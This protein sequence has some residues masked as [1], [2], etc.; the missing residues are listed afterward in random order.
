[1]DTPRIAAIRDVRELSPWRAAIDALNLASRR[2]SPFHTTEYLDAFL[3]ND[4]FAVP[5]TEPLLLL[6]LEGD[7]L[8]GF[9][10]LRRRP[11]RVLGQRRTCLE[12][13]TTHDTERPTLLARPEDERRCAEAFLRHVVEAEP[14]WTFLE[15][16]EQEEGSPLAE[17]AGAL[18]PGRFYVRRFPNNPNATVLFPEG[19]LEAWFRTLGNFRTSMAR[20][21]RALLEKGNAEFLSCASRAA[22]PALLELYLDLEARSWKSVGRAGISRHPTRVELFRSMLQLGCAESPLFHWVLLD[23]LP[24][25]GML[26]LS[27]AGTVYQ[28]ELAYDE[29]FSELSAG[30]V[31]FLLAVRDAM[32]RGAR[33]YNLLTNFAYHK[34]R[35]RAAITDT[36]AVQVY[37]RGSLHYAKARGGE[38][39]RRF[40]GTGP[41][42]RHTEFNLSKPDGAAGGAADRSVSRARA[43]AILAPLVSGGQAVRLAGEAFVAAFPFDVRR[44]AG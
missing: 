22:A 9:L 24:I 15:L 28:M 26:S 17:A 18:D 29:G 2:V 41:S 32:S 13:L 12:F 10:P 21:V 44:K 30:N 4:E 14:R 37:R 25:A 38:L 40:L 8:V 36:H 34:S 35:W 20:R 5:G 23:G 19:G 6:A 43:D 11:D 27:F 1:M 33:A 31:L 3:A 7:R 16:M 42:Q 39:R